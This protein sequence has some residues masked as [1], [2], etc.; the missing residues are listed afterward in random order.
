MPK[1]SGSWAWQATD[2]SLSRFRNGQDNRSLPRRQQ[3]LVLPVL[4]FPH[5][6]G[7]AGIV[8]KRSLLHG[9]LRSG[10]GTCTSQ[11][12]RMSTLHS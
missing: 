12:K 4:G 10:R 9:N 11:K 2:R 3:A 8:E 1:K 6:D 5:V 7:E